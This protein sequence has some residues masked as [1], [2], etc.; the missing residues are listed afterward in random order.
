MRLTEKTVSTSA[1]G[2]WHV[3]RRFDKPCTPFERLCAMA[4]LPPDK[5][6]ELE[7]LRQQTN[8][9]R[10]REEIHQLLDQLFSLPGAAPGIRE[11]VLDTLAIPIPA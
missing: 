2:S 9:R 7:R 10:L 6:Q 4:A 3:Q 1:N 5:R 11:N 8:P